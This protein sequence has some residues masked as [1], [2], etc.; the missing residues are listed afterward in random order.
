MVHKPLLRNARALVLL[1]DALLASALLAVP[2]AAS[3]DA[4][5]PA[6]TVDLATEAGA[7]LLQA[8]WRYSDARIVATTFR[9]PNAQGQPGAT[10]DTTNDILPHAGAAE[11]DDSQW[12]TIAPSSLSERRGPGRV[13]FNWYRVDL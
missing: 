11:F 12:P 5:A 10:A 9:A 6:A 13:S 4:P 1:V 2:P 3:A 8:H 7:S